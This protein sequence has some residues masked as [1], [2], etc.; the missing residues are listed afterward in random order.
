MK[1]SLSSAV[2]DEEVDESVKNRLGACLGVEI[3]VFVENCGG[4][5][6]VK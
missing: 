2:F 5:N 6:D 4:C 3:R 1:R